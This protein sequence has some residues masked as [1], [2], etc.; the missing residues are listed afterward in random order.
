MPLLL[1]ILLLVLIALVLLGAVVGLLVRGTGPIEK[2]V[3]LAF[4]AVLVW[5][6]S[7]VRRLGAPN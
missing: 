5:A 7:R 6:A 1:R 3:L 2:L 4:A